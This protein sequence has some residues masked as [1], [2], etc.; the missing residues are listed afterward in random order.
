MASAIRGPVGAASALKVCYAG[1]NKGSIALLAA[2]RTFAQIEGVDEALLAE[3]AISQPELGKRS[4][5]VTV[6]ARKAWRWIAEM[7]EIAS[8]FEAAGL[9]RGFHEA[10]ADIYERLEQFKDA[11]QAPAMK[12]ITARL[13]QGDDA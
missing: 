2:I 7:E 11:A 10:A 13:R 9:P 12:D 3:W 5:V 8:S 1:W 4:E 6:Q